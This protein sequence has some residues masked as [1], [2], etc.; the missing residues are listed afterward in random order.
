M[1]PVEGAEGRAGPAAAPPARAASRASRILAC[2]PIYDASPAG[3]LPPAASPAASAAASARGLTLGELRIAYEAATGRTAPAS[4]AAEV[5]SLKRRGYL[6]A[7]AGRAGRTRYA[8]VLDSAGQRAMLG[9]AA[10]DTL[11]RADLD[12]DDFA[13]EVLAALA[14]A[15][16]QARGAAVAATAVAR[17]LIL[18]RETGGVPV[19]ADPDAHRRAVTARVRST[20]QTL[21]AARQRGPRGTQQPLVTR[22]VDTRTARPRWALPAGG[23]GSRVDA[24][25]RDSGL[26]RHEAAECEPAAGRVPVARLGLDV[27]SLAFATR[28]AATTAAFHAAGEAL[29]RPASRREVGWYLDAFGHGGDPGVRSRRTAGLPAQDVAA[30]CRTGLI[31]QRVAGGHGMARAC[32]A[33]DRFRP[34]HPTAAGGVGTTG[35]DAAAGALSHA[36]DAT[37]ERLALADELAGIDRLAA[38]AKRWRC[39]ALAEFAAERIAAA[40]AVVRRAVEPAMAAACEAGA[41]G[42]DRDATLR[43]AIAAS[44]RACAVVEG[45]IMEARRRGLSNDTCAARRRDVRTHRAHLR[46]CVAL[47]SAA[48]TPGVEPPGSHRPGDTVAAPAGVASTAELAPFARAAALVAGVPASGAARLYQRARRVAGTGGAAP[49]SGRA[50]VPPQTGIDRVEALALMVAATGARRASARVRQAADLIGTTVRNPQ[51]VRVLLAVLRPGDAT[52]RHAAVVAL[53]L[54][55]QPPTWA[56]AVGDHDHSGGTAEDAI[57]FVLGVA[58]AGPGAPAAR[59]TIEAARC[60]GSLAAR[61]VLDRAGAR[62]GS[63]LLLTA[64]E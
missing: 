13:G 56:D 62:L 41:S 54:L 42:D 50:P 31:R 16:A 12:A 60:R 49:S 55:G 29:G 21:A 36:I 43:G 20:L 2:V 40:L 34:R 53:G 14:D 32:F 18:T 26:A 4:F 39:P 25:Q 19:S 35:K 64:A 33:A 47:L 3:P 63:G 61:A 1:Q 10:P 58:L 22:L 37:V 27:D 28:T 52:T 6:I 48:P 24:P 45:W 9:V 46:A 57:A 30:A 51:R 44:E 23:D 7:V 17:T 11:L 5:G 38:S 15:Q 8:R 59:A